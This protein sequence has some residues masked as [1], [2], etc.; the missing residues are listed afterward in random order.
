MLLVGIVTQSKL[1]WHLVLGSPAISQTRVLSLFH[2]RGSNE[3]EF[4][5]KIIK[6]KKKKLKKMFIYLYNLKIYQNWDGIQWILND[7]PFF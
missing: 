1:H 5:L 3:L 2:E 6:K 4:G 7:W